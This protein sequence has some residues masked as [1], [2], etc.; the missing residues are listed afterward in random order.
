MPR[1]HPRF[2]STPRKRKQQ[3]EKVDKVRIILKACRDGATFREAGLL[4]GYKETSAESMACRIWHESMRDLADEVR[5]EERTLHKQQLRQLRSSVA[6]IAHGHVVSKSMTQHQ[7]C[8][9]FLKTTAD[10]NRLGDLY[11]PVKTETK[12][13]ITSF[14]HEDLVAKLN[15]LVREEEGDEPVEGD[16]T[17]A[18]ANTPNDDGDELPSAEPGAALGTRTP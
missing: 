10:L 1:K 15:N 16:T 13:E 12:H 5:D 8:D 18:T 17:D 14:V 9:V 6:P 2:P 4:A 11:A 7:A 3:V